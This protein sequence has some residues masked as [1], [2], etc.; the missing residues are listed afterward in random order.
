MIKK[1]TR[2]EKATPTAEPATGRGLEEELRATATGID[3]DGLGRAGLEILSAIPAWLLVVD[4]EL[5]VT[6]AN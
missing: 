2:P 6:F 3:L 4:H 5:R 1:S